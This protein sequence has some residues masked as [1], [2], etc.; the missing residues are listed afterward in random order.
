MY[1]DVF[2]LSVDFPIWWEN[3]YNFSMLLFETLDKSLSVHRGC[4][5]P[6]TADANYCGAIYFLN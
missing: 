3:A 1:N 6:V 5:R 4:A 2:A